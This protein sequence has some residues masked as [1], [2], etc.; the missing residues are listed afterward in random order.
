MIDFFRKLFDSDFMPHGHC[1][2]MRPEIIWL[3]VIS[4]AFI[5]MAYFSI[6]ITL[7]YFIRKRRDVPF[8]W[9][10]VMFS[11]F[12]FACGTTHLLEIWSVWHGTYRLSGVVKAVTAISSIGT[13]IMLVQLMPQALTL[14]TPTALRRVNEA[15]EKE[16]VERKEA[17]TALAAARDNLEIQVTERT[18]S[19][20]SVMDELAA[21]LKAMTHLHELSTRLLETTE[22]QPLLEEVLASTIT[23][24][25]ADFGNVQLYNPKTRAL[26]IVAH[27]GFRRDFLD[28]FASVQDEGAACGR[29]IS[30]GER[31]I[32][33]DV[34]T[35][36][37]FEPHR[38]IAASAGFR[39]VH[40]TPLFSRNGQP[41]GMISTHFRHPHRPLDRDL[42]LTD[43]YARQ[44]A[45]L[46][47]RNRAEEE[48]R[49]SEERFRM[50][51]EGVR[52]YAILMLD[53][54][55]R[56]IS[57]NDGAERI[58]G[59]REEEILGRHYSLFF[60]PDDVAK[61]Q[62]AEQ[63]AAAAAT[64]RIEDEGWRLRKDGSRF[65]ANVVVTAI[66]NEAN[67]L[68]GFSNV[69]RDLTDRKRV[70]E[71]LRV[72]EERFRRYFELGLIGMA[73]TSPTKGILEVNDELC[74]ILGYERSELIKKTWA[75]M[76]HPEDLAEDVENFDRVMAG[77]MDGYTLDKRWIRKDGRVVDSIMAAQC[78]RRADE[79]VDYFVG[80][81]MDTT[82]RKRAEE[83]L[84]KTQTELE[85]VT[86]ITT[87]GE[88]AASIAHEV[89]QPLGA[90]VNNANACLRLLAHA[91]GCSADAR[92]ALS[93]I[94]ADANRASAVI[95]RIRALTE[96]S[97]PEKTSLRPQDVVADVLA[98]AHGQL[99]EHRIE[100]RTEL[101]EDLRDVSGD[102]VQLQQV[103]LNLVMN[104]IEAMSE[105]AEARRILTI[106]GQSDKLDDQSSALITVQD[107]GRG[108]QPQ[109][110]ERLFEAFYTTKSHGM[111]MGLR[112][113]RSIVEAHGGRLWATANQDAG[114][115][116]SFALPT[117]EGRKTS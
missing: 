84:L 40:S 67:K 5:T 25:K 101:P 21:E 85:H 108:F 31:I 86:R 17:Q 105:V 92:G 6:P 75:E 12:I 18:A 54:H 104:S 61:G 42:R 94:L 49:E 24:N 56:I 99:V 110:G 7:M 79:S 116:F 62:P 2:L 32:I 89:N 80:L 22:I 60:S 27:R 26:E 65:W 11:V 52:D 76:T 107:L 37:A 53:P 98:L 102:R 72:S 46:I 44:A 45:E 93:D 100:V 30:R 109:D 97:A 19:L 70:E 39:S 10:F 63:L 34:L 33:E 83:E 112:I 95:A 29:A 59:Y 66:R 87:M 73:I 43:L 69:T 68:V 14:P 13:A 64:G 82:A 74:R 91:P 111:G 55:G 88:L 114:A 3:H 117:E 58:K 90:I 28:Y 38:A 41:L 71:S 23:L 57:W 106:R 78:L 20:L 1:Y 48:L 96:R 9:I 50:M 47:E 4:D 51:V 113:S 35:D 15:L 16:I 36:P 115:T 8:H 103:L 77:E 81:V